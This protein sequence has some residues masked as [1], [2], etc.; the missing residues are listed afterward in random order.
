MTVPYP[1]VFVCH[2]ELLYSFGWL[3]TFTTRCHSIQIIKSWELSTL[4]TTME[5]SQKEAWVRNVMFAV[6][7]YAIVVVAVVVVV[8]Y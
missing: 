5:G 4:S 3:G 8:V 6:L 2:F 7:H 1:C